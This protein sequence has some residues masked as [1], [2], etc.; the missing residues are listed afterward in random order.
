MMTAPLIMVGAGHAHLVA[1]RDW[2]KQG[3]RAPPAAYWSRRKQMPG[4]PG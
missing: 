2:V 1:L 3:Y 4:T